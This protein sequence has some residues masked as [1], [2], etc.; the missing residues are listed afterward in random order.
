MSERH[1]AEER[2]GCGNPERMSGVLRWA[3]M[4]TGR[5]AGSVC[6]RLGAAEGCRV[7][8]VASREIGRARVFA[9]EM[10][11]APTAACTYE[12]LPGRGDVDAVYVTLPTH[13][14]GAWSRR[15]LGA[16]KHVV[17]EKPLTPFRAEAEEVFAAAERAERRMVEGFMYVHHPQT[18]RLVEIGRT[19]EGPMSSGEP[20][21]IGTLTRIE[22]RFDINLVDVPH[23]WTRFL[24]SMW[25]GALMDLGCY[26]IGLAR[27]VTGAEPRVVSARAG[28]AEIPEGET[29]PV[30]LATACELEFDVA[31]STIPA[32]IHC[33]MGAPERSVLFRMEGEW[34]SV[35]TNH[36]FKAD[37]ERAVLRV[38]RNGDHPRGLG[39]DEI[40]IG[41]GGDRF[42][43]QFADFARAV[44]G[45]AGLMP[46]AAWSIG[47]A[48]VME[49]T[50]GRVGLSFER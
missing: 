30:D 41:G 50:L 44:R 48:A 15:L 23:A 3:V 34:G 42:E 29:M 40:V 39:R 17:C 7:V 10:E 16:G 38:E 19:G 22:G 31:G 28:W 6:P 27:L 32:S 35:E 36:P 25:G 33:S 49:E 11:L 45:E 1:A 14:H 20:S 24:H 12:A 26:P 8:C 21:V 13:L 9:A 2:S 37:P 47:Q 18:A 5:I 4:G 43:N 46:G